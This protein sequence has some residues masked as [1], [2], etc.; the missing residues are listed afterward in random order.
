[1][2]ASRIL[3]GIL[4]ASVSALGCSDGTGPLRDPNGVILFIV[5]TGHAA[6]I[7]A[8]RSDG[9]DRRRLTNNTIYDA[10]PAWSPDGR[11]ILVTSERDSI[12]GHPGRKA[13][14]FV[15]NADG[16]VVQPLTE[17]NYYSRNG[18]WSP[19]GT[20][21][22]FERFD[23]ADG[24]YRVY[25]MNVDGTG[26]LAL[27]S[28]DHQNFS[29]QW[30]PDG[31]RILFLSNRAP[32]SWWT[33]YTMRPD[34]TDE[35]QLAAET[36]CDGNVYE[37]RWSPDGSRITYACGS[38]FGDGVYVMNANGTGGQRLSPPANTSDHSPV[39]SPDGQRIAFSS[40]RG[41]S[42]DIWVMSATGSDPARLSSFAEHEAPAAWGGV[43]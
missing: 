10:A 35:Q 36:A 22:V 5:G 25:V 12:P 4:L 40:A 3:I 1:M 24:T 26:V 38:S 13:D 18:H 27:T 32:R 6:D 16:S 23:P 29:A 37:P 33:M 39:W 19:D 20:R 21:V 43:R 15:M 8:M 41:G 30:S 17:G 9:T 34:G 11:R 14:L 31:A 42:F 28:P 2:T 7:W